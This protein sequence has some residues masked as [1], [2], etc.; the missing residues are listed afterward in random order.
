M[1]VNIDNVQRS[2]QQERCQFK[3]LGFYRALVLSAEDPRLLGRV[4]VRIPSL[5]P[6][7]C[8]DY[9]GCYNERGLWALPANNCLGGRNY[10][11]T[12]GQRADFEDAWFQGSCMIPPKGSWVFVFFENGDPNHPYYFAGGDFGQRKVLP[13]CQEGQEYW[14]NG[15]YLNRTPADV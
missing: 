4:L 12:M 13:E 8:D 2:N 1:S 11:D 9:C 3:W 7:T 15:S 10:Q 6:E 14:K 5:M